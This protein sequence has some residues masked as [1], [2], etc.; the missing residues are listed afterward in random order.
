M[1]LLDQIVKA[2]AGKLMGGGTGTQNPLVDI[3]MSLLSNPQ[4]G[5]LEGLVE[6]FKNKGMS[7]LMSSWI[8]TGENLPVSGNQ[9]QKALGNDLIRQ[10]AQKLGSSNDEVSGGLANL[11]P[12]LID[13]LTP[14]GQLPEK[15]AL[16]KGL[17]M[18][19]TD[20]I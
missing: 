14:N 2:L 11:L 3:A 6:M 8:S 12:D 17:R 1:G 5:G 16:Q 20:S 13:K 15:D 18:L 10:F 19:R 9:I 7:D 4:T